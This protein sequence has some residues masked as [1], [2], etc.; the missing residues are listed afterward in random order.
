MATAR[1][2]ARRTPRARRNAATDP[3]GVDPTLL[4]RSRPLSEFLY[5]HYWR[6]HTE[7]IEHIPDTGPVLIVANHSGGIPIDAAMIAA[8]VA[9]EHPQQRLVRFLYDRFVAE[10]PFV[11]PLFNRF[12][13]A[14]A[15]YKNARRLL[16]MGEVVGIFPE[17]VEGVAKT[18]WQRYELQPF[19]SSFVRLSLALRVPIIPTAVVGAEETYP[20]IGK[21]ERLGPLR[22]IIN[23]PYIPVTP[24]FPWLGALGMIPL[25]AK[26][27]I[28]F[29][30]PL[31]FYADAPRRRPQDDAA[32]IKRTEQ[33]RRLVQAMVHEVLVV[34]ESVF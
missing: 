22:K 1:S 10:V 17:G 26:F 6:V 23:V 19:H 13:A 33:V 11:G 29:G 4:R 31:R 20:V 30:S 25:P 12:G 2:E 5:R 9:I 18:I 21:F 7:G 14:V 3:F 27:H 8:A 34:R 15:S 28:R 32:V 24:L 16:K